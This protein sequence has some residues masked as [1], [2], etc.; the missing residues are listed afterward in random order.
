MGWADNH[1]EKLKLG[2]TVQF[3]PKG[4]SM[5][6]RIE[7]GELCTVAPATEIDKGDVVL[8]KVNGKQ[9]LHLVKAIQ[10]ERVQIGNNKGHMN[11]WT[12]KSLVYGKLTKVEK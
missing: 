3:R 7:S 4:N 12:S 5:Q 10:G 9:F 1:I 2:E 11:G 6:G 8:C